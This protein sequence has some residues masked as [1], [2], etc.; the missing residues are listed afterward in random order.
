MRN[1]LDKASA[2]QSL[3]GERLTGSL[4]FPCA[5]TYVHASPDAR[6][7]KHAT[8]VKPPR[9]GYFTPRWGIQR[10][11]DRS[12]DHVRNRAALL[13][14]LHNRVLA[15]LAPFLDPLHDDK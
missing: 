5:K 4:H 6:A 2:A 11:S 10:S 3:D 8:A 9:A 12:S 1:L 13:R 7:A 15:G 14:L